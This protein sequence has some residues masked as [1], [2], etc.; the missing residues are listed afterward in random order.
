MGINISLKVYE[1]KK[2]DRDI[3]DLLKKNGKTDQGRITE[4]ITGNLSI[5]VQI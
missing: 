5:V 4:R 1:T 3:E 2:N